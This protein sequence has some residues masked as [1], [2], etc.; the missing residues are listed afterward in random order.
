M[1]VF[2]YRKGE[3]KIFEL[4]PGQDLPSGWQDRP[5]PGDHP[6]EIE[7]AKLAPKPAEPV[8]VVEPARTVEAKKPERPVLSLKK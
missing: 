6:H 4:K 3:A 5:L 8:A 2:G 7:L 1:Q